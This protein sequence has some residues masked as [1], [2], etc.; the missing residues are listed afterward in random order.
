MKNI[1]FY[2]LLALFTF[3]IINILALEIA[4]MFVATP[5]H[6]Q[7]NKEIC[8]GYKKGTINVLGNRSEILESCKEIK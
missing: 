3:I 8:D 2:I 7:S 1:C 6:A 5:V 4:R